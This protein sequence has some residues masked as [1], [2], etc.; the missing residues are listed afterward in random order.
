MLRIKKHSILPALVA[1]GLAIPM[2]VANKFSPSTQVSSIFDP[3]V[4]YIPIIS[5]Q[6]LLIIFYC[7]HYFEIIKV[8]FLQLIMAFL[9]CCLT[10]ICAFFSLHP[11]GFLSYSTIWLVTPF[12]VAIQ[13]K[14][15][16]DARVMSFAST[17]SSIAY[18]YCPFYII[19]FFISANA[20]GYDDFSSYTLA[21]NGHTFISMLFVLFIQFDCISKRQKFKIEF[22]KFLSLMIYM[23]G[24]VV[25][26]G[27]VALILMLIS[28]IFVNWN[29]MKRA[30]PLAVFFM[31]AVIYFNEKT[32]RIYNAIVMLDFE[33]PV[34]WSSMI[35]R[36]NFWTVFVD[37]FYNHPIAGVGGLSANI[38][39]YDYY[40]QYHEFVDPHNEI[41]FIISGFGFL[42][43]VFIGLSILLTY[44]F[45]FLQLQKARILICDNNRDMALVTLFFIA[46]CSLT[47]ANSAKQNI[48]LVMCFTILYAVASFVKM[49][50]VKDNCSK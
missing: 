18:I 32:N 9:L 24:G 49:S 47:N 43:V 34:A 1:I 14:L 37:I 29:R 38:V 31:A 3:Q 45:R 44:S 21:S 22:F 5:I 48:E 30:L 6:T 39:K 10:L 40:F 8:T 26:Q 20:F 17:L 46:G 2:G 42:G 7:L 41:I 25:S 12:A 13:Y 28:T 36:F 33:D 23:V 15:L 27:R 50:K 16:E 4:V 11:T 35:S 19:D